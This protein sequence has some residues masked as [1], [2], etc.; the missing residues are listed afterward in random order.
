[1]LP[2]EMT[3]PRAMAAA[4]GAAAAAG[5]GGGDPGG[6]AATTDDP[7]PLSWNR[8]RDLRAVK[9][10]LGVTSA[11]AAA[12]ARR[13]DEGQLFGSLNRHATN[14]A[15]SVSSFAM[16]RILL[17]SAAAEGKSRTSNTQGAVSEASS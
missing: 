5:G 2:L 15:Y 10:W 7:P 12:T 9:R 11:D 16:S 4:G 6:G 3:P 14:F 17:A 8:A 13:N 1:M